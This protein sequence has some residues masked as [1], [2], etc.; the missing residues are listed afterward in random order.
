MRALASRIIRSFNNLRLKNQL[1]IAFL[2][3]V[4]VPVLIAGLFLTAAYRSNVLEQAT[5][6]TTNNVDKIVTQVSDVLRVPI[7]L[8]DDYMISEPLK[9]TVAGRYET[10]YEATKALWDFTSF[11]DASSLYREVSGIR[12]YHS[13]ETLLNNGEFVLETP[14][15]QRQPWHRAAAEKDGI[16]WSYVSGESVL[17]G[18]QLSLVRRIPFPEYRSSGILVIEV[19]SDLFNAML[20]Q[21]PY[22]TV[23]AD[24]DGMIVAARDSGW[25]G[26]NLRELDMPDLAEL[27]AGTYE[28]QIDGAAYRVFIEDLLPRSSVSGLRIVSLFRVESIVGEANRVALLGL[29][30]LAASMGV[31]LVLIWI[32]SSVLTRRT[33]VLYRNMSRIS[34]GDF[35][36]YSDIQGTDEIGLLSRQFN[37]MVA[38]I[39]ELMAEVEES[40]RQ[41]VDMELRQR[42][43]KLKMMASQI[44]PHFLFNALESIRMRIHM[45]GE[46]EIASVV[47]M[48]GRL[49]R[50]NIEIGSR[51]IALAEE[52]EI[53]RYYL[54]IQKF[55]YGGERLA[56][57]LV[58]G[59][60]AAAMPVPP[61]I[62]Q[63]LVENAVV[64]GLE[65]IG[66]GGRV[67]VRAR[68]TEDGELEVEVADNGVGMAPERLEQVR[69]ALDDEAEDKG[70]RIGLRNVHQRL[71]LG[72]GRESGLTIESKEGE[73][74]RVFFR[75]RDKE[76]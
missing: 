26:R 24:A 61:L 66:E 4:L 36:V 2:I 39:R 25:V 13:N 23:I 52:L 47:R 10:V 30:V 62:V 63:T 75:I 22:D 6:Q 40:H 42:D 21:E 29:G 15:I 34:K 14:E 67:T 69:Q 28:Q 68:L 16:H 57:E 17:S 38:N 53:V 5:R 3:V 1:F 64:H 31:G 32:V 51:H 7:D 65:G 41:R 74:T 50:N 37:L 48:L 70:H 54:E 35:N 20:K 56:Y 18:R 76:G 11:T 43:I 49:I 9:E 55:R 19:N 59:E 72:F 71:A 44:N 45:K 8:S 33:L 46:K 73:G 58:A 12:M 27:G 60:A